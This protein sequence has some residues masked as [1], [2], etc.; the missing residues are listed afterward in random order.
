MADIQPADPEDDVLGNVSGVV[1]DALEVSS[2]ENELHSWADQSG[3]L[4]H[5]LHELVEDAVAVLIDDIVALQDLTGHF[6]V[7]KNEGAEALADHG[8]DRRGHGSQFLRQL[9]GWHVAERDNALGE[10]YG[11]VAD[12]LEIRSEEHT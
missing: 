3:L 4:C 11:E 12:A 5:I 8:A 7:A 6:D 1:G 9:R 2:S 10:I